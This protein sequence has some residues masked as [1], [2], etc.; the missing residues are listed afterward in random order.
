[1]SSF[2][3]KTAEI[4]GYTVLETKVD[5]VFCLTH[6]ILDICLVLLF[7]KYNFQIYELLDSF[8]KLNSKNEYDGPLKIHKD[9]HFAKHYIEIGLID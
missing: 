9:D 1:M 4:T 7:F 2:Q 6:Y 5:T 3:T 8:S